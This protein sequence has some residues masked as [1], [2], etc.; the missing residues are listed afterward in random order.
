MI[1]DRSSFGEPLSEIRLLL[2]LLGLVL[3]VLVYF[4]IP[5]PESLFPLRGKWLR[6][7]L[8]TL[9]LVGLAQAGPWWVGTQQFWSELRLKFAAPVALVA[10]VPHRRCVLPLAILDHG[11]LLRMAHPESRLR[12]RTSSGVRE[13]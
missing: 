12:P 6:I 5:L 7:F 1:L 13:A 2:G 9:A 10:A 4:P 3:A 11:A 8:T